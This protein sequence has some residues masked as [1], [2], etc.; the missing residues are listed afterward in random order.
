MENNIIDRSRS[1]GLALL[2]ELRL[3]QAEQKLTVTEVM[4]SVAFLT[5]ALLVSHAG[6]DEKY[7]LDLLKAQENVVLNAAR[8]MQGTI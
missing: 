4:S 6:K 3:T 5:A 1:T 8:Y 7:L 2:H